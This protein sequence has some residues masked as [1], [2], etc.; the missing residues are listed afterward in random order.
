DGKETLVRM[1]AQTWIVGGAGMPENPF[2]PMFV[3]KPVKTNVR[4]PDLYQDIN[5]TGFGQPNMGMPGTCAIQF[6]GNDLAQPGDVY[7]LIEWASAAAA[8]VT[9][10]A[11]TPGTVDFD[12]NPAHHFWCGE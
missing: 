7:F 10:G 11:I 6:S 4:T 2:N 9:F 8:P 5:I 3:L 12:N 1:T